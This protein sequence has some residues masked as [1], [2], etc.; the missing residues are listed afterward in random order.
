MSIRSIDPNL[1]DNLLGKIVA[2]M[3]PPASSFGKGICD[4]TSVWVDIRNLLYSRGAGPA[5]HSSIRVLLTISHGLYD[6]LKGSVL[7]LKWPS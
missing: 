1:I 5:N 3:F 6:E 4:T 2:E 7:L